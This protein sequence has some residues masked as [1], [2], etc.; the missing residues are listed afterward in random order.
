[1]DPMATISQLGWQWQNH[2]AILSVAMRDGQTYRV[3]VPLSQIKLNF[4]GELQKVGCPVNAPYAVGANDAVGFFGAIA[5]FA[6]RAVR[7]VRKVIPKSI[8]RAA[9]KV[10]RV[11]KRAVKSVKGLA[12]RAGKVFSSPLVKKLIGVSAVAF[13]AL[14][15]AVGGILAAQKALETINRGRRIAKRVSRL[16]RQGRKVR[17][18]KRDRRRLRQAVKA[19]RAV[20]TVLGEA[21]RGNGQAQQFVGALRQLG[22]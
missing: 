7:S 15:P 2:G 1:M 14:A 21:K 17:L 8:R 10:A 9:N 5:R 16:R 13:P 18:R 4:Y 22:L 20:H 3:F 11:A 6:K 19:R 12:K